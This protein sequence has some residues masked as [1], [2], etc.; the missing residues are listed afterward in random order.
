M[1]TTSINDFLKYWESIRG[2]TMKIVERIPP[3]KLEWSPGPGRFTLG[4][5]AR[6]LAAIE[7]LQFA[8]NVHNRRSRYTGCGRDLA[9]G[10]DNVVAFMKRMHEEAVQVLGTLTEAQ[11]EQKCLTPGNTPITTWKWLRAMVEHE[12][13]HRGQMYEILGTL[14]VSTP[15]LFGLSEQQVR[16]APSEPSA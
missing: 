16:T 6:H 10:Y 4:D 12:V 9:D 3:D 11:M 5:L 2:R 14:G 13:H 1:Y 15:P 8:E 7:R